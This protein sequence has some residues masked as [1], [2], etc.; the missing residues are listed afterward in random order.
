MVGRIDGDLIGR[1]VMQRTE[2]QGVLRNDG[3]EG[4]ETRAHFR[5]IQQR[6]E[7]PGVDLARIPAAGTTVQRAGMRIVHHIRA[8]PREQDEPREAFVER[9]RLQHPGCHSHS[10]VHVDLR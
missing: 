1:G 7:Q 6:G 9:H 4:G 10:C 5:V 2:E 8:V 3:S